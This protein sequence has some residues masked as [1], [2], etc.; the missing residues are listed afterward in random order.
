MLENGKESA[1]LMKV[2]IDSQ[3]RT[4]IAM[5]ALTTNSEKKPDK[6]EFETEIKEKN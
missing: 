6:D 4:A 1:S 5:A 2:L 3:E